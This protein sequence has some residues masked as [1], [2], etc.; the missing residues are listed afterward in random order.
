MPEAHCTR[1]RNSR[2][3]RAGAQGCCAG[4]RMCR[5][6]DAEEAREPN[7]QPLYPAPDLHG[8]FRPLPRWSA[9]RLRS[10]RWPYERWAFDVK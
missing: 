6:V 7:P 4:W 5:F 9:R 10:L 8:S 2:R 3:V 1:T